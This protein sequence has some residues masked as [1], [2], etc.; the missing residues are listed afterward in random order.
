MSRNVQI[1]GY[2]LR[3]INA[4]ISDRGLYRCSAQNSVGETATVA[5]LE[6]ERKLYPFLFAKP[7]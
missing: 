5:V 6:V 2:V 7:S 4:E 3:I 1:E